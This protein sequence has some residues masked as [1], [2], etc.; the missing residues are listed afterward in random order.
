MKKLIKKSFHRKEKGF[1]LIE[2]LIVIVIIGIL[3]GVL[4]AVINPV[5]QQNRARNATVRASILKV[6]FAVNS[7]RAG[8][9]KLPSN[10]EI[11]IE[12][13]NMTPN[14]ANCAASADTLNCAFNLSGTTMPEYCATADDYNPTDTGTASCNMRLVS[15][16]DATYGS[17]LTGQFRVVGAKFDLDN[18]NPERNLY[19]FDSTQGLLEC[20]GGYTYAGVDYAT[21]AVNETEVISDTN[22]HIVAE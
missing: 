20:G 5:R 22:C 6:A 1:T 8:I 3:A 4:I 13:E 18:V 10:D 14:T 16:G 2:L 12:L 19:I 21:M 7:V 11:D 15:V 17:L 9:G